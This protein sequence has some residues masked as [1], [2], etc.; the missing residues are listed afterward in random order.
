MLAETMGWQK[1]SWHGGIKQALKLLS[2][3]RYY[4]KVPHGYC[5]GSETA[6]YVRRVVDRYNLFRKFFLL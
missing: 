2:D 1:D 5:H 6:A 3:K 4:S